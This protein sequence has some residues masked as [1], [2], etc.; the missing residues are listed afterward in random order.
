MAHSEQ[1]VA[2]VVPLTVPGAQGMHSRS[3]VSVGAVTWDDPG[4]QI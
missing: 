2:F 3:L 1:L 4:R